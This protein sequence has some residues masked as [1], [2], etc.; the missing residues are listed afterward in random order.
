MRIQVNV[1]DDIAKRIDILAKQMGV[2]RS[3]LCSIWIAQALSAAEKEYS[4]K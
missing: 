1:A 4:K 3:S 2:S